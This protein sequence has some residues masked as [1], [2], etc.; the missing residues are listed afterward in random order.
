MCSKVENPKHLGCVFGA[1]V[2]LSLVSKRPRDGPAS[3]PPATGP[4]VRCQVKDKNPTTSHPRKKQLFTATGRGLTTPDQWHTAPFNYLLGPGRKTQWKPALP[5]RR[6]PEIMRVT[7]RPMDRPREKV[8]KWSKVYPSATT[9][10]HAD[11]EPRNP[12]WQRNLRLETLFQG[13]PFVHL[14][15]AKWHIGGSQEPN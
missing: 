13:T 7:G 6:T 4:K 9:P 14:R 8:L 1:Q 3:P 2:N 5:F 15:G 11:L 12:C 10:L